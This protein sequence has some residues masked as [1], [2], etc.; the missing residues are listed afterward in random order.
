MNT[1]PADAGAKLVL[2]GDIEDVA[3]KISTEVQNMFGRLALQKQFGTD[4][5]YSSGT[6]ANNKL[7]EAVYA[8]LR[9]LE[10]KHGD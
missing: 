1:P 2:K 6:D 5:Q 10:V 7:D 3:G 8:V 9:R 4:S